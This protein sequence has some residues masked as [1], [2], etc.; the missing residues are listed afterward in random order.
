MSLCLIKAWAG[1]FQRSRRGGSGFVLL[2]F[3]S[4][5][6]RGRMKKLSWNCEHSI[7][8]LSGKLSQERRKPVKLKLKQTNKKESHLVMGKS[9]EQM[10]SCSWPCVRTKSMPGFAGKALLKRST[11][12]L[13]EG[14]FHLCMVQPGRSFLSDKGLDWKKRKRKATP[15]PQPARCRGSCIS[16]TGCIL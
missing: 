12:C 15:P 10:P 6:G 16:C 1:L 11:A 14:C 2:S 9:G 7:P 13:G 5:S 3:F 4:S 8:A